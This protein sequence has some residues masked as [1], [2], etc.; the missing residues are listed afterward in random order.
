EE[1][2]DTFHGTAAFTGENEIEVNGEKLQGKN[3]FIA[4]GAVPGPLSFPDADH[5]RKSADF[6]ELEQLPG[7][8]VF[9]G[10]GYISFEFAHVAVRAGAR[11]DILHRGNRCLKHFDPDL[12]DLLCEFSKEI[13]IKVHYN[14]PAHSVEKTGRG[15]LVRAGENGD[16]HLEADLVVHGAGRVAA[17][18]EMQLEKGNVDATH[19][20]VVVN[21]Y[22]QSVSNPRVYAAG[23]VTEKG[24]QLTPV[25]LLEAEVAMQNLLQG[26]SRPVDYSG[27]PSVLFTHPPLA[28]VG[29]KEQQLDRQGIPYR[30]TLKKTDSWAAYKRIG[31]K[32]A[33][34]KILV[35]KERDTVLGAH[36]LGH[37][38]PEVINL[39]A[40]AVR[41]GHTVEELKSLVWSYPSF[42][43]A[44]MRHML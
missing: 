41:L 3:I 26:N 29:E 28:Q 13:G 36:I 18:Q 43:Y 23:D 11:V 22:M 20:G 38:G 1:G 33:A 24:P 14:A 40:A 30:K 17:V 39:F 2:I 10:G 16:L 21:E 19:K 42:G 12:V 7:R 15:Y 35:H 34:A 4:S 44:L 32:P 31:E 27:I 25:A 6:L 9:V 8:I 37:G 5:L